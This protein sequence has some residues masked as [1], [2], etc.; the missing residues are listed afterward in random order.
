MKEIKMKTA[1]EVEKRINQLD[2]DIDDLW[3]QYDKCKSLDDKIN[4]KKT[5]YHLSAKRT[6]LE[7]VL[8]E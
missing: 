2:Q 8:A 1:E 4:T 7:W 6:S 5:I 3:L